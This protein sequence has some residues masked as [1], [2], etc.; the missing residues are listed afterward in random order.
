MNHKIC[1]NFCVQ[2]WNRSENISANIL[3]IILKI[4]KKL[5]L[6][7]ISKI[8]NNFPHTVAQLIF[9]GMALTKSMSHDV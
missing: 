2:A 1:E 5:F 8:I 3:I 9:Y 7:F 4:A 6:V